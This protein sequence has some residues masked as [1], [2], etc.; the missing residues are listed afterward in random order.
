V[1]SQANFYKNSDKNLTKLINS[2]GPLYVIEAKHRFQQCFFA[3]AY[4]SRL[5]NRDIATLMIG[6][7]VI[8]FY[9]RHNFFEFNFRKIFV[10]K[11]N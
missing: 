3:F 11:T 6:I 10:D 8:S 1:T 2:N 4:V 5:N 7:C 9:F